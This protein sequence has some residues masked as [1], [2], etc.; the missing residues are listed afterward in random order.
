MNIRKIIRES[1][2][3]LIKEFDYNSPIKIAN[4]KF[5]AERVSEFKD[6]LVD[7]AP[8]ELIDQAGI[9]TI[10]DFLTVEDGSNWHI[11]VGN[12]VPGTTVFKNAEP[13][14]ENEDELDYILRVNKIP[15]TKKEIKE[16]VF[17]YFFRRLKYNIPED[18]L[19]ETV[20]DV[21]DYIKMYTQKFLHGYL[22]PMAGHAHKHAEKRKNG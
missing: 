20:D 13:R 11:S 15:Y 3:N 21:K 16:R 4:Q 1:I 19:F 7:E 9:K 18:K 17:T 2:G 8:Q 6:L 5:M 12:V 10:L 22:I 14:G